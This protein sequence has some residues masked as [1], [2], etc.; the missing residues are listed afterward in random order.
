METGIPQGLPVS[1]I[2]F[3]IYISGVFFSV[4][5]RLPQISCLSFMDNL[6]FL[7]AGHS[8]LE[9]KKSLEKAGKIALNWAAG[10][11]VTY[12]I[13]KIEAILFSKARNAKL[14]KQLSDILLRLGKRT[15]FFNKEATQWLG[16][17]F[18]SRLTFNSHVNEKLRKAKIV[19]SRIQSQSKTYGLSPA[20]FKR[21]QIAAVQ[22]VAL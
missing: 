12:D 1:P 9:I 3:L 4:E 18:D 10:H 11:A 19:E 6:G 17:W 14:R 2:L 5:T 21:I 13:G 15:I 7:V 16:M 22:S 20:L 8:M